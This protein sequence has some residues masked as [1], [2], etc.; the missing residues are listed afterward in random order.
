M[1]FR[2]STVILDREGYNLGHW[3]LHKGKLELKDGLAYFNGE[4]VAMTRF[5]G[6]NYTTPRRRLEELSLASCH[7]KLYTEDPSKSW[8]ILAKDYLDRLEHA[9]TS[10]PSTLTPTT[11]FN[12]ERRKKNSSQPQL[13]PKAKI[14]AYPN[15]YY[16]SLPMA[17]SRQARLL[18][19]WTHLLEERAD[20]NDGSVNCS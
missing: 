5:S 19:E 17:S 7:S 3:N 8:A 9:K 18:E 12:P 11:A 15:E 4:R 20:I 14:E 2:H 1:H 6:L 10:S 13:Y 16:R